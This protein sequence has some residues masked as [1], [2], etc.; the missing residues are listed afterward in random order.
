MPLSYFNKEHPLI[1]EEIGW[2]KRVADRAFL[3]AIRKWVRDTSYEQDRKHHYPNLYQAVRM[4]R[5]PAM[6]LMDRVKSS[7]EN[8]KWYKKDIEF[9]A[10]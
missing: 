5:T 3:Q 8:L 4:N 2:V 7:K 9:T 1:E 10:D 6:A